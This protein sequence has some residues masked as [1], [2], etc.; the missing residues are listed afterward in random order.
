MDA[1]FCGYSPTIQTVVWFGNDD[2]KPMRVSETGGRG[3]APV[4]AYFY[5]NWIQVHPE[6]KR[7]FDFPVSSTSSSTDNNETSAPET[8]ETLSPSN[9]EF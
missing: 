1:W 8:E 5:R 3:A 4:V 6:T 9:V 7:H 2:N